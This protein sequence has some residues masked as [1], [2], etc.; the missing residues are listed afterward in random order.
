MIVITASSLEGFLRQD[1][2]QQQKEETNTDKD[3]MG[4]SVFGNIN[5]ININSNDEDHWTNEYEENRILSTAS[6]WSASNNVAVDTCLDDTLSFCDF[7][8]HLNAKDVQSIREKDWLQN[9]GIEKN[10]SERMALVL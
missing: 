9:K 4:F 5:G 1:S 2:K 3:C 7:E 10:V 8:D 6:S